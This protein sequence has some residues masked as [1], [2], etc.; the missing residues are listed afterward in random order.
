MVVSQHFMN[1]QKRHV[2]RSQD[3]SG[4]ST[5]AIVLLAV[6]VF[7]AAVVIGTLIYLSSLS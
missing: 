4:M 5:W 3:K 7:F 2:R 6:G 1:P